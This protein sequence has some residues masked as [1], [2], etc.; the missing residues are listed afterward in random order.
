MPIKI[1]V[2]Q[3]G[4]NAVAERK[5]DSGHWV[6]GV[7]AVKALLE[8]RPEG[9]VSAA[10][11]RGSRASTLPE[12]ERELAARGIPVEHMDRTALDRL[13]GGGTH[14]GV[15]VR[16][17]GLGEI[18]IRD[19]ESLVLERG[20]AL[21]L[22][23]LDQVQDPRNL[24]ACLRT[25]DAAGVDAVVVPRSRSAKL[26][27]VAVKAAAGAAETVRLARVSNLASTLHWLKEAGVWVVGADADTPRSLHDAQLDAPIAIVVGGEGH[28]LRRLTR[29]LCDEI[30]SIPLRGTVASLNV[31]VAA[32]VFLFEL[33]RQI[34]GRS[35]V[36]RPA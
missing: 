16:T 20:R 34:R 8:R 17:R 3:N 5:R 24:G 15:A 36:R 22:L 7:H 9:V 13:T 10:L 2:P 35:P 29:E 14:Q 33:D 6:Y 18:G 32:A 30:V 28:G 4:E 19:L 31:S 26:T 1:D 12:I 21:R 23:V 27:P 11:L 25:A